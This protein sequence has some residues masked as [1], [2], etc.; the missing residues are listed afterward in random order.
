M[1]TL[2]SKRVALVQVEVLLHGSRNAVDVRSAFHATLLAYVKAAVIT[3]QAAFSRNHA[4]ELE[5][6]SG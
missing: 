4:N 6:I 5:H 2:L 3:S 1:K